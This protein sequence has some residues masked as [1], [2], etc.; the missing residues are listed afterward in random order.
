MIQSKLNFYFTRK[1]ELLNIF[2]RILDRRAYNIVPAI[3]R[4]KADYQ[5]DKNI[6]ADPSFIVRIAQTRRDID[7]NRKDLQEMLA[8]MLGEIQREVEST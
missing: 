3:Y 6:R 2:N 5:R 4:L 7:E 1:D 8:I